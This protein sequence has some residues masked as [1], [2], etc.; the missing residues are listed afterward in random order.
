MEQHIPRY[1][2][3]SYNMTQGKNNHYRKLFQYKTLNT[4]FI[5][6]MQKRSEQWEKVASWEEWRRL[7]GC[8]GSQQKPQLKWK[9]D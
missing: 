8:Y 1:L 4:Y 6:D 9:K 5:S 7:T 3:A 2:S